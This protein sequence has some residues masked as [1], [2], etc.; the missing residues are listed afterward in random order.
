MDLELHSTRLYLRPYDPSD[1]ALDLELATDPEVMRYFGGAVTEQQALAESANF[2]RRCAG[3]CIGVWTVLER[4]TGERLGEVFLTPLPIDAEDTQWE[5]IQGDDM[6]EGDIEIGFMLKRAAWG[7][8]VATEA[9]RRLLRFAFEATPLDEIVAVIE[10][11]NAASEKVLL[12]CGLL[13]EASRR[14]Y[15]QECPAFRITRARFVE[16]ADLHG[17]ST[18]P[19][20]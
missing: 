20:G 8:G 11:G 19:D 9:C 1:V 3:G 17:D 5:L 2:T 14:A 12:K 18:P 13:R 15:G 7:R 10:A 6:P 16:L 4:R